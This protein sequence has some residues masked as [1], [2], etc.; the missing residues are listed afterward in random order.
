LKQIDVFLHFQIKNLKSW[1]LDALLLTPHLYVLAWHQAHRQ[2][3]AAGGPKTRR[4]GQK[5]EGGP[6]FWNTVLDVCSNRWVK[7]EMGVTHLKWGWGAPPAPPLATG[8]HG[9]QVFRIL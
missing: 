5:P 6:H 1:K 2:D 7:P 3:V 9:T 8:L 4:R